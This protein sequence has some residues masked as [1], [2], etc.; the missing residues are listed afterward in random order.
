MKIRNFKKLITYDVKINYY[1][2]YRFWKKYC[3]KIYKGKTR[4]G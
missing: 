4:L 1:D 3:D 2:R